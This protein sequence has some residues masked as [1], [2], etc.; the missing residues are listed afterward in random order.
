[1]IASI[2]RAHSALSFF[3]N[4]SFFFSRVALKY[5]NCSIFSSGLGRSVGIVTG[6]GLD[7]DRIP[8]GARFSAPV[9]TGPEPHPASCT[10]GTGSFPEV[11]SGRGVTLTPHPLLVPWS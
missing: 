9:Q 6:Y 8:V 5:L 11:K 1:M 10:M 7:G 2:P 3:M 4:E